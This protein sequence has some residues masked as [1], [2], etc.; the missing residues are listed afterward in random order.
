VILDPPKQTRSRE[1]ID[2][3]LKRYTAGHRLGLSA[4]KPGGVLLTCSCSGL[5][6]EA[7]FLGTLARAS[8]QVGRTAQI[9]KIT[10]P[11]V[12]HPFL[13]HVPEGRYLKAVWARIF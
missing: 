1:G 4:V 8:T 10:G 7:E 5:I 11:G 9:F 2:D 6:S 13:S 12:D 3:A